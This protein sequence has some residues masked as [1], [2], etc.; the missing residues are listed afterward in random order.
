MFIIILKC[1]FK[2]KKLFSSDFR[3][4]FNKFFLKNS[5]N[6]IFIIRRQTHSIEI[7]LHFVN[8]HVYFEY[9]LLLIVCIKFVFC[10]YWTSYSFSSF[11]FENAENNINMLSKLFTLMQFDLNIMLFVYEFI[12]IPILGFWSLFFQ[13]SLLKYNAHVYIYFYVFKNEWMK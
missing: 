9:I 2:F 1:L 11:M 6:E 12:M 7:I 10:V 13:V 4:K 3:S 5:L 8:F